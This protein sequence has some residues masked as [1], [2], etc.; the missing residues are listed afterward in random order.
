V[1]AGGTDQLLARSLIRCK[2]IDLKL[3]GFSEH[4]CTPMNEAFCFGGMIWRS[5]IAP[6]IKNRPLFEEIRFASSSRWDSAS[7]IQC[8]HG[9]CAGSRGCEN[10]SAGGAVGY[11]PNSLKVVRF[12]PHFPPGQCR[13]S[14]THRLPRSSAAPPGSRPTDPLSQVSDGTIGAG[15]IQGGMRMD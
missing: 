12:L 9:F 3:P 1:I 8:E 11:C 10:R 2:R 4:L 7:R 6:P 15:E 13:S 14:Q 5:R